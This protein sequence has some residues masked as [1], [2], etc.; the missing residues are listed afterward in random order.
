MVSGLIL[1]DGDVE[2]LGFQAQAM[3]SPRV[4]FSFGLS[5]STLE[6]GRFGDTDRIDASSW[7]MGVMFYPG[8]QGVDNAVT[9]GAGL[10]LGRAS[11]EGDDG[12][13]RS[14]FAGATVLSTA[15]EVARVITHPHDP[16]TVVPNVGAALSLSLSETAAD[17]VPSVGAGLG[18]GVRFTP[19]FL[20]AIEP[21]ATLSFN[22]G[23]TSFGW[24]G[25][26]SIILAY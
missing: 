14:V 17:T 3:V 24:G 18:L 4:A 22:Q 20:V 8:R 11:V 16:I 15:V 6:V 21:G 9:V 25:L 7:T 19:G 1:R 12:D 13:G 26:M 2:G 5:S 23:D 10:G